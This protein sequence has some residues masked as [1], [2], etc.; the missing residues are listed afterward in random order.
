[1]LGF[2]LG[3]GVQFLGLVWDRVWKIEILG[4]G[5]GGVRVLRSW[6][7]TPTQV[8]VVVSPLWNK[9][10]P[11]YI[12][13]DPFVPCPYVVPCSLAVVIIDFV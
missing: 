9:L 7:H 11:N 6:Q 10:K 12:F 8:G 2:S 13:V 1:M 3:Y 5:I 4:L